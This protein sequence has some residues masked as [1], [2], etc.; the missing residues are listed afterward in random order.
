MRNTSPTFL[1]TKHMLPRVAI[2]S[3]VV[4]SSVFFAVALFPCA[5]L[6]FGPREVTESE[7]PVEREASSEEVAISA[8]SRTRVVRSHAGMRLL[9]TLR[10]RLNL[11]TST[12]GIARSGHRLPNHLLAPLR[13]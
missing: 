12:A 4:H 7:A 11:S 10:I 9:V 3:L 2:F 13:C 1:P 5:T 6:N 8:Q